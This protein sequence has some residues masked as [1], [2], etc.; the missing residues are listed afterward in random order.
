[1]EMFLTGLALPLSACMDP[2]SVSVAT[3]KRGRRGVRA[4][5]AFSLGFLDGLAIA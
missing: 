5:L 4:A 2:G 3:I 1:M